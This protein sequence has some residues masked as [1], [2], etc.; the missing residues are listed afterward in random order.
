MAR[1]VG[2]R[3]G[4]DQRWREKGRERLGREVRLWGRQIVSIG[5][6]SAGG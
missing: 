1:A 3:W 4:V 2:S 6:G 5:L